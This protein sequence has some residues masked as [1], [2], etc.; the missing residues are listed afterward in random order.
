[1][2]GGKL[3]DDQKLALLDERQGFFA[4]VYQ[5]RIALGILGGIGGCTLTIAALLPIP[6]WGR[7]L[8]VVGA[9]LLAL[10]VQTVWTGGRRR[11]AL[12]RMEQRIADYVSSEIA[13]TTEWVSKAVEQ[14]ETDRKKTV[15]AFAKFQYR[16]ARELTAVL[17]MVENLVALAD[18]NRAASRSAGVGDPKVKSKSYAQNEDRIVRDMDA[19]VKVLAREREAAVQA[20]ITAGVG[21]S[22]TGDEWASRDIIELF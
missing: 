14:A 4:F 21:S 19:I 5:H 10:C 22:D 17:V 20:T 7:L 1:M 15:V 11:E 9:L 18:E 16:I 8:C 2:A 3:M 6:W 12:L 13:R